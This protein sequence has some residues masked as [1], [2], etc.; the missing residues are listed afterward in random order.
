MD[1]T[2]YEYKF[3]QEIVE[4]VSRKISREPLYVTEYPVGLESQVLKAKSLMDGSHDAVQMIGIHG[5]GGIGKTTLAK[6]IYNQIGHQFDELCFLPNVREICLTKRGLEH[7]QEQLLHKIVRKE[8]MLQDFSEGIPIIKKR[9]QGK[10]VLLILDDVDQPKQLK[11]LAG[12]L[13]WFHSGSKV[14]VTTRDTHLLA[15]HGIK[16]RYEVNELN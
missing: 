4:E 15:S 7:L 13:D 9:L 11:A 2:G 5:I 1:R 16:I 8:I 12:G 14:I 6:E 3:I 10:K